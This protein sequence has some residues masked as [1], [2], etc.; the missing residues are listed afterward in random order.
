MALRVLSQTLR[1]RALQSATPAAWRAA[2]QRPAGLACFSTKYTPQHEYVTLNGKEGTIGITDFAQNSLGDVVYVDLP[3]V[4]DK[5]QKGDAFGA[6][7][8]VKAASD[9]Y[10][11]ASGTITAVN[12]DLAESPNLVN[13]EAMTGGWFIKLELDDA[14]DL[15]DLL[16]EAAYKEH[17][18][19]E[20]H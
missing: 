10:T 16:D 6:V 1:A 3:S 7:E 2:S 17:C 8:S 18:E 9:V 14:S 19:N 15:D 20:E 12:E 4:G 11:P 5:F 13:D